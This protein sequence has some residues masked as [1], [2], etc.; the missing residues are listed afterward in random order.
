MRNGKG[1]GMNAQEHAIRLEMR[2]G[3]IEFLL[4][5]LFVS[6]VNASGQ[7]DRQVEEMLKQLVADARGQTF[8]GLDPAMSDLASAEWGEA[9]E[10]LVAYHKAMLARSRGEPES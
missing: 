6:L 9:V 10:R 8:P 4:A 1:H 5:R 2:L 3:A 7:S